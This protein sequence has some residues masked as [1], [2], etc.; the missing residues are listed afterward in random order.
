MFN[1][2]KNKQEETPYE[3]PLV[4]VG[5]EK[6]FA[7]FTRSITFGHGL[8]EE[9]EADPADSSLATVAKQQVRWIK[10]SGVHDTAYVRTICGLFGLPHSVQEDMVDVSQ[11][12]KC[13]DLDELFIVILKTLDYDQKLKTLRVGQVSLALVNNVVLTF[14]DSPKVP[15]DAWLERLRR[16]R[17]L[18]KNDPYYTFF[19]LISLVLD[20]YMTTLG[21]IAD[22]VQD[23]EEKLLDVQTE[24]TLFDM[25]SLKRVTAVLRK[26]LWPLREVNHV[27]LHKR[28]SKEV[29][30]YGKAYL[31]EIRDDTQQ[32]IDMLDMLSSV[33]ASL[34]D[35]NSG[36]AD[37]RMN[38]IMKVLTVLGTVF[39]PLTFITSLY[40]MNFKNMPELEWH[41]G[42][43]PLPRHHDQHRHG[44][45]G[46]VQSQKMAVDTAY[47]KRNAS[48]GQR[49]LLKKG[50]LDSPKTF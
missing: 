45:A 32:V 17:H 28:N 10:V 48:G 50:S 41:W 3:E 27:L 9:Q 2:V 30:A 8:L 42:L 43:L 26:H 38:R 18:K 47:G 5:P 1:P 35:L 31:R 14:Q 16:G 49:T 36:I 37:M 6:D 46:L 4:Y 44:H 22:E 19:A 7:P 39:L 12:P 20:S 33:V 25:Y 21:K 24:R 11:R 13:E 23:M 15:W 29:S 34:I 40:G